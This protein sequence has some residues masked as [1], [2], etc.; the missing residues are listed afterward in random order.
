MEADRLR[1]Y[2]DLVAPGED[3]YYF[4][5]WRMRPGFNNSQWGYGESKIFHVT[6][7]E[8]REVDH[9]PYG[10]KFPGIPEFDKI[11]DDLDISKLFREKAVSD[12]EMEISDELQ[13]FLNNF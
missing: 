1:N 9:V 8:V 7:D 13:E 10:G 2:I 3:E 6:R 4:T 11:A 5:I 12:I